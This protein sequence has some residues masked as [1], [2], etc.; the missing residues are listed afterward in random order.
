MGENY[1]SFVLPAFHVST[2]ALQSLLT[3]HNY[4]PISPHRY[5][6]GELNEWSK[7]TNN[8]LAVRVP[9]IIRAPWKTAAVGQHTNVR[10]ELV[11]LYRTLVD[12]AGL[13]ASDIQADVQ[14]MSRECPAFFLQCVCD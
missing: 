9:L 8:E 4:P 2:C 6:L 5:Q 12:L 10:A 1:F 11:D 3:S 7:K 14:G 13:N